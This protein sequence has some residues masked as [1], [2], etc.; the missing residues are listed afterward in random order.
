MALIK[1]KYMRL[2]KDLE[3]PQI[4]KKGEWIDLRVAE[5]VHLSEK[6]FAMLPLGIRVRLPNEFEAHLV[7]R[8]ST[9]K[10]YKILQVNSPGIIDSSYCGKEDE[11]KM[12]VVALEETSIQKNTRVCQ[13]RIMPS[14]KASS[15]V[16]NLWN[17]AEGIEL[18]E[19]EWLDGTEESRGGF[20]STGEK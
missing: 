9:F 2:Q 13:F 11:W 7:P 10:N 5:D 17:L 4:L 1:I 8:S 19:E 3:P 15:R 14:Q 16:K 18:V 20:G 6:E 12:A